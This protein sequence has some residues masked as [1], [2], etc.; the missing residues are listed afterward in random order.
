MTPFWVNDG[1]MCRQASPSP[2]YLDWIAK[3]PDESDDWS[4]QIAELFNTCRSPTQGLSDRDYEEAAKALEVEV[5]VIKAVS[6]VESRGK[7]FDEQGRPTILF[8]RHYF[9]RLTKR[10]FDESV[11]DISNSKGGGY[12]KT[13]AQ[14][15]RLEKAW[16]LAAEESLMSASWGRFQIMGANFKKAGFSSVQ[17]MVIALSKSERAHLDAFIQFVGSDKVL[18]KA[19][20]EKN[21]AEF[22]RRYNGPKYQENKYDLKLEQEYTKLTM[23]SR[24]LAAPR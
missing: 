20:R 6:A 14:M 18:K 11:P 15:G 3:L 13:A 4:E 16:R 22:A 2:G 10:R 21:W 19:L 17:E 8:E 7:P 5:E 23:S 12:G 9:S 1:T 24:K